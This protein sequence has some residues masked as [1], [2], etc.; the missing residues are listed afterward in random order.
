MKV[1][2]KES[3]LALN[4]KSARMPASVSAHA[5]AHVCECVVRV[6]ARVYI[7]MCVR[8]C[9]RTR[10]SSKTT[11]YSVI[12]N[13]YGAFRFQGIFFYVLFAWL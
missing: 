6:C 9:A 10:A 13:V 5:R 12:R 3:E 8:E 2:V 1:L 7:Y 11:L 4:G